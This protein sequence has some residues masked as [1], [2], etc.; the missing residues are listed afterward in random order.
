LF[1]EGKNK[2]S[3]VGVMTSDYL[4]NVIYNNSNIVNNKEVVC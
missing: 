2:W 4:E 3:G 1:Q